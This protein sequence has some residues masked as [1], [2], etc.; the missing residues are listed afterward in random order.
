MTQ[1][2]NNPIL[3]L[4]QFDFRVLLFWLE[5]LKHLNWVKPC[6]TAN[7]SEGEGE[8][9]KVRWGGAYWKKTARRAK[10]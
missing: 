6:C 3:P 10:G 7:S 9:G 1:L 4:S 8:K 2:T 5:T